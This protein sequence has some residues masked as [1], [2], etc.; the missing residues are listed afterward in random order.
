MPAPPQQQGVVRVALERGG[1][2]LNR[3][4]HLPGARLCGA[5]GDDLGD[6]LRIGPERRLR[7]GDRTGV[8]V[9]AVLFAARRFVLE[10]LG[11]GVRAEQG[12]RNN[13]AEARA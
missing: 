3:F 8:D 1:E 6:V 12:E 7:A 2:C 10:R 13:K 9:G 4:A 11:A 5:E